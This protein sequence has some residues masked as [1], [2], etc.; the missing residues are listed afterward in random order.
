MPDSASTVPR[1]LSGPD[2]LTV[3]RQGPDSP[4]DSPD[5]ARQLDSQGSATPLAF[6]CLTE[7]GHTRDAV[8]R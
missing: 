5:S 7:G 6:P 8:A 1:Q 4:T 3:P 2:S